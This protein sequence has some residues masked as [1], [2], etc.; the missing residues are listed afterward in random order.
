ME[1]SRLGYLLYLFHAGV[2]GAVGDI[3]F[4]G[5]G[6]QEN[7]L[8]GSDNIFTE[9]RQGNIA[10]IHPVDAYLAFADIIKP[11]QK[12]GDSTLATTRASQQGYQ[13]PGLNFKR[14]LG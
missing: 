8:L 14:K 5:F 10:D 4:N 6:K 9:R 2:D 13:L 1:V 7:I 11:G 12:I 3:F